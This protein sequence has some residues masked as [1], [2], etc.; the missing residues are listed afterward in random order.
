MSI[1]VWDIITLSELAGFSTWFSLISTQHHLN[2][3][4]LVIMSISAGLSPL[5]SWGQLAACVHCFFILE[6]F[7]LGRDS[8]FQPN[9]AF[10]LFLMATDPISQP[11]A[12]SACLAGFP[13]HRALDNHYR[14]TFWTSAI[15]LVICSVFSAMGTNKLILLRLAKGPRIIHL[16]IGLIVFPS[17]L[18]W[19]N[20][21]FLPVSSHISTM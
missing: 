19:M 4:R 11:F 10:H 17:L 15:N 2:S 1:L 18:T 13:G 20:Q 21:I 5:F 12:N 6:R 7:C 9:P 14:P 16:L 3:W 8:L